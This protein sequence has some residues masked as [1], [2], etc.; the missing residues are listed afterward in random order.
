M[1]EIK[2]ILPILQIISQGGLALVIFVIW[3][4]TFKR[5]NEILKEAFEKHA[6]LSEALLQ[7]IKEDQE[8]KLQLAS[9]FD[10]ILVKLD[11]P[12][13]CPVLMSGKRIRLEVAE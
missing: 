9:I 8:Y 12:A 1:E 7:Q 4:F 10:R 3:Y 11:V 5:L 13:Q 6:R 2:S